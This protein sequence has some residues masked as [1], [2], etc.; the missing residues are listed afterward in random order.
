MAR[1]LDLAVQFA[2]VDCI[3]RTEARLI[4]QVETMKPDNVLL[5]KEG[6]AQGSRLW[7]CSR[8]RGS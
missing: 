2:P 1:L 5:T 6:E 3:M 7:P 8:P 4:H